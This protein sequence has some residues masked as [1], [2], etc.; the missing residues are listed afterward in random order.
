MN[1]QRLRGFS[2]FVVPS[3][4]ALS[5]SFAMGDELARGVRM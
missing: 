4:D 2:R 5:S 1:A 3:V